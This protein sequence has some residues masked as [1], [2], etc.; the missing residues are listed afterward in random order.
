MTDPSAFERQLN[1]VREDVREVRSGISKI[2]DAITKLAVLEERHQM[3]T[4]RMDSI[5]KRLQT[6]EGKASEVE[7]GHLK[8]LHTMGGVGS[9]MRVMWLVFGA[10]IAGVVLKV[11]V[12]YLGAS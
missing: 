6:V 12:P 10:V 11:I 2:A 9:T 8:L 7:K 3:T 4:L 1:E 5:D